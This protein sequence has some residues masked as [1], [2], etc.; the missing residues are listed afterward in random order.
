MLTEETLSV[1]G[2]LVKHEMDKKNIVEWYCKNCKQGFGYVGPY[3]DD[4][5]DGKH[6]PNKGCGILL[7][8]VE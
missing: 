6:C 7:T 2:K 3:Y 1:P 4:E 8:P 5:E